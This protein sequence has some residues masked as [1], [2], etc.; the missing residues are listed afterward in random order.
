MKELVQEDNFTMQ[1][2]QRVIADQ[3]P[4]AQEPG[5]SDENYAE[6]VRRQAEIE[7]QQEKEKIKHFVPVPHLEKDEDIDKE[8]KYEKDRVK[9]YAPD[10][11]EHD[12]DCLI[13]KSLLASGFTS[14]AIED[15]LDYV[16][17]PD[18]LNKEKEIGEDMRYGRSILTEIMTEVE[19][20][21]H[22]IEL[23]RTI[24]TTTTTTQTD[25]VA[26]D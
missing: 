18:D 12:T 20:L 2:V 16:H 7:M 1:Q 22:T 23:V 10:L 13:A 17:M 15:E 8:Y 19:T 24:E 21:T 14:A 4:V 5:R 25:T 11:S 9:E 6:Y 3:S 26:E